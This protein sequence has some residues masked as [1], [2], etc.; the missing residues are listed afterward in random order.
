MAQVIDDRKK[1]IVALVEKYYKENDFL[2]REPL[3]F[4]KNKALDR[5]LESDLSIEEIEDLIKK[6]VSEIESSIKSRYDEDNVVDNHEVI[7]SRLEELVT[8]LNEANIDY[9]LAGALC[10]YIK[11]GQESDRCHDDIDI[12][13]N[14]QDLD[15]LKRV[16]EQMGL[17]FVD[18]RLCTSRVLKNG[19]PSGE[20][21]VIATEDYSDFHIGVFCFERLADGTVI[22]KGYYHDEDNMPCVREEILQK[23]LASLLYGGEEVDFRGQKLKITLPEQIYLMKKYT[24]SD[25]DQHDIAFLRDRIDHKKVK[26]IKELD[27]TDKYVQ[28]VP[29]H[30]LPPIVNENSNTELSSMVEESDRQT[31]EK[32]NKKEEQKVLVKSDEKGSVSSNAV[33]I[34]MI[35]ITLLVLLGIL[36][37]R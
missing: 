11:Y 9:Q 21:E 25:K 1:Q 7:Y 22:T 16:L 2:H 23:R 17:N 3:L 4:I 13:V 29:V 37:F 26:R 6:T 19:I 32:E 15:K 35:L 12:A 18:N 5:F 34:Q 10:G 31:E 20:H 27:N 14:E 24:N 36:M 33:V 8:L 28:C 30:D